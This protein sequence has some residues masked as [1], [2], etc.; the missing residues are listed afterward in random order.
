MADMRG[1]GEMDLSDRGGEHEFEYQDAR[2]VAPGPGPT[3][4][5]T[6]GPYFAYG[7]TPGAYGYPFADVAPRGPAGP[8]TP[9]TRIV[10]EGQVFDGAGTAVHDALVEIVQADGAGAYAEAGRN[11]GFI[12]YARRGTGANGPKGDTRFRF[13]TVRPGPTAPGAA[14]FVTVVVTMRGLLNHYVTRLYFPEDDH[15]ADPVLS[16]VPEGRR[17]T[18]IAEAAGPGVY[19][20]DIR[21]QGE[22][23]TVFFD[24]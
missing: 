20:F 3:P 2:D 7:L 16:Q 14:P 12:G 22:R 18:L 5:Q 11:D 8:E 15:G 13:E 6:V 1:F 9:G 24:L 17:A 23:E 4:S 19:R 10:I 21:M